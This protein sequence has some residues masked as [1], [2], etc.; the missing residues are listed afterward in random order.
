MNASIP[1][2]NP[3]SS[4]CVI[5]AQLTLSTSPPIL[6]GMVP[7]CPPSVNTTVGEA[8]VYWPIAANAGDGDGTRSGLEIYAQVLPSLGQTGPYNAKAGCVMQ[9]ST[10]QVQ[11]LLGRSL[12]WDNQLQELY[13]DTAQGFTMQ[14]PEGGALTWSVSMSSERM[15]V[16]SEYDRSGYNT[17]ILPGDLWLPSPYSVAATDPIWQVPITLNPTADVVGTSTLGPDTSTSTSTSM[18]T[19]TKPRKST[20]TSTSASTCVPQ[21]SNAQYQHKHK[22]TQYC[23]IDP[24]FDI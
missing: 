10:Y 8:T 15:N 4:G 13:D 9:F 7:I 20:S 18:S 19:S 1:M 14:G 5:L 6:Q 21:H 2:T 16:D 3:G 23:A 22:R 17:T 24:D 12:T 11:Y